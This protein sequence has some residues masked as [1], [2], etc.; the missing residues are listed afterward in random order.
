MNGYVVTFKDS[1]QM[2]IDSLRSIAKAF[3][4]ETQKSIFPYNFVNEN[5]L[6]YNG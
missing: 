3:D 2:L 4:V 5:N 6:N 1:Q